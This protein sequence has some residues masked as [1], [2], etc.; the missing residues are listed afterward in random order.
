MCSSQ[1]YTRV[2][3]NWLKLTLFL[4]RYYYYI[5]MIFLIF[6]PFKDLWVL[7]SSCDAF[8]SIPVVKNYFQM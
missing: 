8:F 6:F 1:T 5:K 4:N 2:R 7:S 3:A